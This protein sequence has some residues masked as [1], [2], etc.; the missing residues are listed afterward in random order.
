MGIWKKERSTL[1]KSTRE[2]PKEQQY[3]IY[4][5]MDSTLV[6]FEAGVR[7]ITGWTPQELG[8]EP[9]WQRIKEWEGDFFEELEWLPGSLTMW[10]TIRHL[11]P[12]ILTGVPGDP[13]LKRAR[14]EKFNWCCKNLQTTCRHVDMAG[15]DLSHTNVNG[16]LE[17]EGV[18]NIITCYSKNKHY[19]SGP[20]CILIDDT[21][22][23]K[24]AW[25]AKDGIFIHHKSAQKTLCELKELGVLSAA[26]LRSLC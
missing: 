19:E 20:G 21:L 9:M 13:E 5:D 22:A 14:Q 23:L 16:V 17:G 2:V 6:D 12:T 18:T 7:S 11:G 3:K 4:V 10:E 26:S 8:K 15:K 1:R 24:E 25:V